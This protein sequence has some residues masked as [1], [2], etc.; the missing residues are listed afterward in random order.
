M[1][2]TSHSARGFL[3]SVQ[4][5]ER[6]VPEPCQPLKSSHLLSVEVPELFRS[7][8]AGE[9]GSRHLLSGQVPEL[10]TR[11]ALRAKRASHLLSEQAVTYRMQM[12]QAEVRELRSDHRF[13][14]VR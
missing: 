7:T 6:R 11:L 13:G 9:K 10:K 4:V 14:S 8:H 12:H 1:G 5:P 2:I 3:L